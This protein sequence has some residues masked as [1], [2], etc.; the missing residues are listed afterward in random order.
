MTASNGMGVHRSGISLRGWRWQNLGEGLPVLWL[1]LPW[2]RSL[3]S[4]A[5]NCTVQEEAAADVG[6]GTCQLSGTVRDCSCEYAAVERVNRE[7]VLPVLRD[8]VRQPFFRYFKVSLYC[9]CPFWPDDGMCVLRDCSVC[10]CEDHEVPAPWKA[11]DSGQT[12]EGSPRLEA[13]SAVDRRV[14]ASTKEH[15]VSIRGWRGFNNPWMLEDEGDVEYSYINLLMNPERYTGYKGE[16]AHRIW[17]LIYSQ[18][19]FSNIN[20]PDTCAE[21]RVFYRLISGMHASISAHIAKE[22]LLDERADK[23]GPNLALFRE[24]LG[25]EGVRERVENLYFA[26][27]FVLRA[28]LKAGPLLREAAYDTGSPLEDARTS[29]LVRKLVDSK[30][31]KQACPVP[32]DEGRLWKGEDGEE[33]KR[34]LQ[35]HFHNITKAMDC[36]GCEKCKLWGKLQILGIATSLKVLFSAE[37]CSGDQTAEPQL[38]LERNEVIAMLNLLERLAAS[39][40]VVREMSLQLA[41]SANHPRGLGAIEDVTHESLNDVLRQSL[42]GHA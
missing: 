22:Y 17:N 41:D 2:H 23:W 4:G 30:A 20:D 12:C 34:Q 3:K 33:L 7:A 1:P 11:A 21:R 31:V 36:V 9:D 35:A 5:P 14:D 13:E 10:P 6:V 8:L 40:E 24:R 42:M 16:H 19:C 26:Y 28:A 37:D 38:K 27:L 29:E 15:L 25:N 39:I 32:F 18:S